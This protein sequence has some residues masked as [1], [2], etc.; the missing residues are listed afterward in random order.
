VIKKTKLIDGLI[1]KYNVP[2][3]YEGVVSPTGTIG[4]CISIF[5]IDRLMYE[6]QYHGYSECISEDAFISEYSVQQK[7][8]SDC[9]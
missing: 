6:I 4:V 3:Y 5:Q 8:V 2:E 1:V 7:S 9:C